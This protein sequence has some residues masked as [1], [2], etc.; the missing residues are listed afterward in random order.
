MTQWLLL[1]V[2]SGKEEW[3]TLAQKNYEKKINYFGPFQIKKIKSSPAKRES[4]KE[5]VQFEGQQILK[6]LMSEDFVVVLDEAGQAIKS[7]IAFSG[8]LEKTWHL[9]KKEWFL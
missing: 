2:E 9:Q 7:S 6:A 5:K 4:H 3:L 1:Y 8:W